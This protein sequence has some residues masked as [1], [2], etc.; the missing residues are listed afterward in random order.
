MVRMRVRV[1]HV[2]DS[3]PMPRGKREVAIDLAQLGIDL[4]NCPRSRSDRSD[5]RP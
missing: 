2:T 1:D 5:N 3:K 4:R